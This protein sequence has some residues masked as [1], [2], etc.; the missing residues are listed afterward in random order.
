MAKRFIIPDLDRKKS[1]QFN[2][3]EEWNAYLKEFAQ[4]VNAPLEVKVK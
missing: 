2:S 1:K 4:K 3:K